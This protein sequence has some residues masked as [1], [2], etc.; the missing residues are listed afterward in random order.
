MAM[1][2]ERFSL[3]PGPLYDGG[4][5]ERDDV[6]G[7]RRGMALWRVCRPEFDA[8]SMGRMA[9][10]LT[11]RRWLWQDSESPGGKVE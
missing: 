3:L 11:N 5:G 4:N 10:V 6:T 7:D 2:L 8:L 9:A 1:S